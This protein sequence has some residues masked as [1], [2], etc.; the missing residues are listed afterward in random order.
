MLMV[1]Y[2]CTGKKSTCRGVSV[3]VI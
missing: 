3:F 2:K 1:L